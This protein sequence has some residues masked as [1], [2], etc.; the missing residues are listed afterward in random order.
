[1]AGHGGCMEDRRGAYRVLVG[2]HE[3]NHLQ[4]LGVDGK[5]IL[6]LIFKKWD[7]GMD[8]IYLAKDRGKCWALVNAVM[9]LRVPKE[10]GE[11][12]E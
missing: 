9:N 10:C 3:R 2:K 1:M 4:D 8:W 11:F 7:G 6:K 12:L 5:M